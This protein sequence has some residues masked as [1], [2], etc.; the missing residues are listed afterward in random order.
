MKRA[1]IVLP[2]LDRILHDPSRMAILTVLYQ[3][4]KANF[5]YLQKKYVSTQGNRSRHLAKLEAAGYVA[6]AKGFKG[7]YP[8]T[9][10]SMTKKGREALADYAQKLAYFSGTSSA[11]NK[12]KA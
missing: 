7:K 1:Q 8:I 3:V 12:T 11:S 6:I 4:E 2:R 9:I 5:R 10:C